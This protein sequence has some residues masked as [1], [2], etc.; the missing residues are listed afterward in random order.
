MIEVLNLGAG[1]QSSVLLLM[2]IRGELPRL[3]LAVFAD[4]RYEPPAV[5][6]HLDWL[7]GQAAAAGLPLVTLSVGD[8]RANAIAFRRFMQADGPQSNVPL[9]VRNPDG[10]QGRLTRQ[11]TVDYKITPIERRLKREVLGL[12]PGR[13][14]P[15]E[16]LV[17]CWFGITTDECQRASYPGRWVSRKA[18]RRGLF[19]DE[20]V[21]ERVWKPDR[22]KVHYYPF[23]GLEMH[24]G[25]R[26]VS[27]KGAPTMD[28][29]AVAGW[30]QARH[31]ERRFPRSACVCCPFRSDREWRQ[32]RDDD[33]ATFADAC[34]FDEEV[35]AADRAGAEDRRKM[36]GE[37][38]VHRSMVP[39]AMAD[40]SDDEGGG[41]YDS[42]ET[43]MCGM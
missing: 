9:F 33:P 3:D 2:S 11:C 13:R 7:K 37:V 5:Y 16:P 31:P 1:L 32:M 22:W 27:L 28:R 24:A 14:L 40:L 20:E 34:R 35:R 15:T 41:L 12:K 10:S 38:Y 43:G 39:L 25:R 4:T 21:R 19:A 18:T 8:L 42:C 17:R 23:L 6:E 36:V 26:C 29:R 30:A